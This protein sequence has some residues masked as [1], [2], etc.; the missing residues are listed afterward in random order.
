MPRRKSACSECFK[1]ITARVKSS[2]MCKSCFHISGKCTR[3]SSS[4]SPTSQTKLCRPCYS[5]I[6]KLRPG[7]AERIKEQ[8]RAYAKAD[9]AR[10]RNKVLAWGRA[11]PEK[12]KLAQR[13]RCEK[14][15]NR[16]SIAVSRARRRGI[17]WNIE[18]DVFIDLLSG[19]S[20]FYCG[21]KN[22][23]RGVG[24]DRKDSKNGYNKDNVVACC[25]PC[26]LTKGD[27]LSS[28]EMKEA[29][30][31]VMNLRRKNGRT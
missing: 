16:Y 15:S 29:M 9:P 27:R 12:L 10:H 18:K 7:I 11:N 30:A 6:Y 19:A 2:G 1:P 28:E 21:T 22:I 17:D 13:K 20:C 31:A 4:I 24:L 8:G 26:N 23:G 3:C 14:I 5:Q 25:G